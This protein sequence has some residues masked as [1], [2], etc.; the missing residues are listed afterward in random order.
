MVNAGPD[1]QVVRVEPWLNTIAL[2]PGGV[3]GKVSV[4]V[5]DLD[6]DKELELVASD[7]G[8][9]T[10]Q[11]LGMGAA[12]DKNRLYWAEDFGSRE[13]W[14]IDLELPSTSSHFEYAV[15]YRHGVV[16]NARSYAFWD[17]NG[18]RNWTVDRAGPVTQ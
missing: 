9:Q 18:M 2:G 8:W 6:Y 11:H 1:Y 4:Q 14:Q 10:V 15:V 13:R 12:G 16:N 5:A 3:T 17:N 7:D